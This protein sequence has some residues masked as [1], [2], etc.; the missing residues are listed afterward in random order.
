MGKPDQESG[1][2]WSNLASD[3]SDGIVTLSR[4]SLPERVY[5]CDVSKEHS[6]VKCY[7]NTNSVFIS[8]YQCMYCKRWCCA[9]HIYTNACLDCQL[10]MKSVY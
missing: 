8:E 9:H 5:V 2:I 7:T 10:D 3:E 4:Y 6:Y 1:V